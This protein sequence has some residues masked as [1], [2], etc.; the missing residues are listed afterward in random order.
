MQMIDL[1]FRRD[2]DPEGG[3]NSPTRTR[4]RFR[5]HSNLALQ[6]CPIELEHLIVDETIVMLLPDWLPTNNNHLI[7][8]ESMAKAV[9]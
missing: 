5:V 6:R 7:K 9:R 4:R 1:W 2:L 8:I 3:V